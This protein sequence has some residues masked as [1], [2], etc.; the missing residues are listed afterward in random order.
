LGNICGTNITWVWVGL[1]HKQY[2]RLCSCDHSNEKLG[3]VEGKEFLD[4]LR[5]YQS[6]HSSV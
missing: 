6:W 5:D 2:Q 1:G 3:S 4:K